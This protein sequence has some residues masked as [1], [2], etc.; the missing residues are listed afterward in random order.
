PPPR[1][2]GHGW[3]PLPLP[4]PSGYTSGPPAAERAS[5]PEMEQDHKPVPCAYSEK[6]CDKHNTGRSYSFLS[7]GCLTRPHHSAFTTIPAPTVA[8]V[9][10]SIRMKPPVCR[11]RAYSSTNNGWVE[12]SLTRPISF[13]DS[14]SAFASRCREL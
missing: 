2:A 14:S 10:S 1:I 6:P 11:L 7:R 13:S 5:D 4:R 9:A 8:L 3:N 12:R